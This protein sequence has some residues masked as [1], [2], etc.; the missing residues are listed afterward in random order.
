MFETRDILDR[1][2]LHEISISFYCFYIC[3]TNGG[4]GEFNTSFGKLFCLNSLIFFFIVFVRLFCYSVTKQ[5][6]FLVKVT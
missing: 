2:V 3:T 4:G 5:N 1:N 6:H